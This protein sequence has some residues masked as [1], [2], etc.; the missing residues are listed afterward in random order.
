MDD[1]ELQ[2]ERFGPDDWDVT[3]HWIAVGK[4]ENYETLESSWLELLVLTGITKEQGIAML[5]GIGVT[6]NEKEEV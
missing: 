6:R 2:T 5:E 4:E 3:R 1:G